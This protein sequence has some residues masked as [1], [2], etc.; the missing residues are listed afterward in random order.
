M[1][2]SDVPS[3]SEDGRAP[4]SKRLLFHLLT[5]QRC[6]SLL[7]VAVDEHVRRFLLDGNVVDRAWCAEVVSAS[8]QLMTATTLGLWLVSSREQPQRIIGFC[9]YHVFPE[10][11][12]EAQL[13]YAFLPDSVGKGYATEAARAAM[14]YARRAGFAKVY[15]AVDEPNTASLRVLEKLGFSVRGEAPGDFGKTLLFE[16]AI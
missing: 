12:P 8:E 10:L 1:N 15:A 14:D 11:Q 7:A 3:G 16:A 4:G 9:G 2:E 6:D 13:I 5:P